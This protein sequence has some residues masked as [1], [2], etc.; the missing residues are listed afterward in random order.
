MHALLRA[1]LTSPLDP[2]F[3]PSSFFPDEVFEGSRNPIVLSR[4]FYQEFTCDFDLTWYPFDRQVCFMN[5]TV[6]GQ[7]A[8]SLILRPENREGRKEFEGNRLRCVIHL[9]FAR[10][11]LNIMI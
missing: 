5:F 8:R 9:V 7:T 11:S 2:P 6:Q 1:T 10:F 3:F 4:E